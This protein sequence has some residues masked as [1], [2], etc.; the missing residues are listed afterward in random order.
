MPKDL[1]WNCTREG[2][3]LTTHDDDPPPLTSAGR[4]AGSVSCLGFPPVMENM[5]AV[6]E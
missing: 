1:Y 4:E 5:V 2:R 3:A 6:H